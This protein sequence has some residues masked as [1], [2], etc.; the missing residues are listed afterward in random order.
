MA[1]VLLIPGKSSRA[2]ANFCTL[3]SF[4]AVSVPELATNSVSYPC[5]GCFDSK[6]LAA[7]QKCSLCGGVDG[8]G[9]EEEDGK[10][11]MLFQHT[12]GIKAACIY[13]Y[14]L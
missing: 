14:S 3:P 13:I 2:P 8:G 1:C 5:S 4:H 7:S 10:A 12:A 11:P 6:S 9:G